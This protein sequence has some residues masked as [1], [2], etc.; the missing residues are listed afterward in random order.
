MVGLVCYPPFCNLLSNVEIQDD[1]KQTQ[2]RA[3]PKKLLLHG[4]VLSKRPR[5]YA[6]LSSRSVF[7]L[8]WGRLAALSADFP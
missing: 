2:Q 4:H 6:S 8:G 5:Y 3:P 7:T 1:S